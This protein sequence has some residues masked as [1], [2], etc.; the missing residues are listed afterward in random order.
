MDPNGEA[1]AIRRTVQDHNEILKYVASRNPFNHQT[2]A[3][4]TTIALECGGYPDIYLKEDYALWA[5]MLSHGARA[6][7]V[8]DILVHATAGKSMYLR[9]GGFRYAMAEFSL[10]RHLVGCGLKSWPRALMDGIGRAIV[11]LMPTL[12]RGWVYERYLRARE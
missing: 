12:V 1:I 2:L 4:R 7:N 5:K 8:P 10:Q 3:Y 9:R 6:I 11:F